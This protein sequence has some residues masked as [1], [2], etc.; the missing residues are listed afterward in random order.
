MDTYGVPADHIFY[1]R[2]ASFAQGIMCATQDRGVDVVFNS[3][4]GEELRATWECIAPYGRFI[5]IG[6]RDILTR[7]KLPMHPFAKNVTF[8]AIDI[9]PLIDR[10]ALFQKSLA[11]VAE[12]FAQGK[13]KVASPISVYSL[14]QLE[15]ALRFLQ[16]GKNAGCVS[17][18]VDPNTLVQVSLNM[19]WKIGLIISR[20]SYQIFRNFASNRMRHMLSRAGWE[21]KARALQNGWPQKGPNICS[22]YQGA[23]TKGQILQTF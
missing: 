2:D 20:R 18:E 5:E 16:S 3:L 1:S 9:T 6:M 11:P 19:I 14:E 17:I 21:V 7:S 4:A 23:G 15:D 12:L 22:L 10:P 8:S 13:L